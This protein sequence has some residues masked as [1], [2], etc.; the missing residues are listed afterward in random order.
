[1]KKLLLSAALLVIGFANA[2]I[3][4]GTNS[5][6]ASAALD[7]SSTSQGFLPPRMTN[8]QM[9]AIA[10]PPA[11]LIVWCT[12]CGTSGEQRVFNGAV[13]KDLTG[14]QG[15]PGADGA[16]TAWSKTGNSGTVA[17][18][19]FI[20]TT[21]DV[22]LVFK[23]NNT[24]AGQIGASNT[25]FGLNALKSNTTGFNNTANGQGALYSNTTGSS[26]TANG[27]QALYTNTT[28]FN[29]TANGYQALKSNTTGFN[30]TAVGYQALYFNTTG[31]S[32]TA[33]GSGALNSNTT[34]NNNTANGYF[35]LYS[36]T[37]GDYNTANGFGALLL[38]SLGSGNTANGFGALINNTTGAYNTATGTSVLSSNTT[39][40]Y[41]TAFGSSALFSN[42]TGNYNTANGFNA[43]YN[44]TEGNYNTANGFSALSSNTTGTNNTAFGYSALLNNLTGSNN[45]AIGNGAGVDSNALNNAT[46]IGANAVVNASN[47]I[48]LGNGDIT[49]V[50]TNGALTTGTVS[51]PNTH[52]SID[53]QVLTTNASGVATWANPANT[54]S[55]FTHY[56]GEALNGGIIYYLYK[57][58]DG[59]EHGLIVALTESTAA[60][61]TTGTVVN[62]NRTE[63]G[64]YNT[65]LMTGSPAATY[66]ATLGSGWYLPS[67]DELGLLYYN[68][69]ST[70]KALRTGGNTLLSNTANYWSSNE[71]NATSAYTFTFTVGSA[72]NYGWKTGTSDSVRGVRAF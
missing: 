13:W 3:G 38:N 72:N 47:K 12:D 64:A 2:Q 15:L 5:P 51:Y 50:N 16:L 45:T 35:A 17:T 53:G 71:Y 32:N 25:S 1:M 11:G 36:N 67:I 23:R 61:Q 60:W 39:G 65:T 55:G 41:N 69:Y 54:T 34:G 58:S 42:T 68:R 24:I 49:N 31:S 26:N 48:Q 43:L 62:A 44:N 6:N 21:D 14:T 56:L 8:N 63:D 46:A 27:L 9:I 57:G 20:G 10:T 7:I 59:L 22:D 40:L 18:T 33:T 19:N 28:G 4:I 66:I 70:Q 29:N 30:N 37:T 52:N